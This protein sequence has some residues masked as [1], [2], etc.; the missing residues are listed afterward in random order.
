MCSACYD[1]KLMHHSPNPL[2]PGAVLEF[3]CKCGAYSYM[4]GPAIAKASDAALLA[5]SP[6]AP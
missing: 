2:S 4:Y 3:M 6:L 1:R 5:R